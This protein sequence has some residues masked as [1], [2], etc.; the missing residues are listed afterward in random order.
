MTMHIMTKITLGVGA[1]MLIGSVIAI[2]VGG[3]S[4]LGDFVENP[5][6]TEKWSGTSPTT[7]TGDFEWDT[8]YYVFVEGGVTEEIEVS[9]ID[10]DADNRFHPCEE[11]SSCDVISLRGYT[12]LGDIVVIDGGTYEVEFTGNGE[13]TIRE[14]KMDISG[15]A[16]GGIGL[17]AFCCSFCVLGLGIV[18]IFVLKDPPQQ[19]GVVMVQP[20]QIPNQPVA[21]QAGIVQEQAQPGVS[22]GAV[23]PP[24]QQQPP[25]QG[26]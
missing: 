6:G 21:G 3:G 16:A 15:F 17:G 22:I 19:M 1:V 8:V 11:D 13:V 23:D 14:L 25:S 10:G 5:N 12:Y 24:L 20:N 26:F 7:Y 9:V 18:F 2:V 4:F